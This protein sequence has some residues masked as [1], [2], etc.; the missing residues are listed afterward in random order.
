MA[1]E[2]KLYNLDIEKGLLGL[3]IL[4][5]EPSYLDELNEYI[6]ETSFFEVRN[7]K[8]YHAIK[9]IYNKGSSID[10]HI[11][12]G[13]LNKADVLNSIGGI[14][15]L[16]EVM[17]FA[18]TP[19]YLKDY[20]RIVAGFNTRRNIIKISEQI[21]YEASELN[22]E[23]SS[24]IEMAEKNFFDLEQ[25][26][27]VDDYISAQE[28]I[29]KTLDI[30]KKR[31]T[32]NEEFSGIASGFSKIDE[33]TSGFQDSELTIIGARPSIGKTAF[34]LSIFYNICI[35]QSIP[36]V[37]FSLE[38][39]A[40]MIVERM[41]SGHTRID[42]HRLKRPNLLSTNEWSAIA[43]CTKI[44]ASKKF[45]IADTPNMSLANI[46]SQ[47]RRLKS[48]ED[49]KIIFIDYIGLIRVEEKLDRHLQVSIISKNLKA[50]ARELR[51]P[52]VVL[53]QVGRAAEKDEP[54][55]ANLAES[56][57]LEQDADMVMFLHRSRELSETDKEK[58]EPSIDTKLI[59]A[60]NRNG[61]IDTVEI[62]FIPRYVRFENKTYQK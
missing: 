38:M 51:I 55:L 9:E 57:S 32:S 36:S 59:V 24:V 16:N 35:K 33:L 25:G 20:A 42:S 47:A 14:Q 2:R 26:R 19:S 43:E 5:F 8:I 41:I 62:I 18:T 13:E 56:G 50:L 29:R 23:V 37:F 12:L 17:D 3:L 21:T 15:Y 60:K 54:N 4:N 22:N 52:V 44:I 34:A 27:Q 48:K 1:K 39:P 28:S 49:I 46:R 61:P 10:Y 6:S 53:A 7:Q 40:E 58:T 45:F 11:L 31:K 30:L